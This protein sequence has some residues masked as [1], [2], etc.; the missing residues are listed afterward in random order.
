MDPSK[1]PDELSPTENRRRIKTE[2]QI[3]AILTQFVQLPPEETDRGIRQALQAIGEFAGVDRSYLFLFSE[4]GT[5]ADPIYEWRA[6]GVETR[7][8][9]L[10]DLPVA[11]FPWW[12]EQLQRAGRVPLPFSDAPPQIKRLKSLQAPHQSLLS[13]SV[14]S[15][16]NRVGFISRD[17]GGRGALLFV[18]DEEPIRRLGRT[19]LEQEGYS[20]LLAG[21]GI[22]AIDLFKSRREEIRLVILDLAMPRQSGQ[23][24][25]RKLREMDPSVKVILSSGHSAGG[26][27]PTGSPD[28][29]FLPKPYRPDDLIQK[30]RETLQQAVPSPPL[31]SEMR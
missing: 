7:Y 3:T 14:R 2:K 18:D 24:A 9:H 17:G 13:V 29:L 10:R 22:E 12:I 23:E 6:E 1:K 26:N 15:H 4:D 27:I 25:F 5:R 8:A 30:A 20:V 16:G 19:V 21:D 28:A 11:V 31:Q